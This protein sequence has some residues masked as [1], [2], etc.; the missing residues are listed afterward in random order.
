[1]KRIYLRTLLA[2][3]VGVTSGCASSDKPSFWANPLARRTADPDDPVEKKESPVAALRNPFAKQDAEGELSEEF[4][5]AQKTLKKHPEKTLLAWA[6]YQEDIGEYAEARKMYRELQIA[7]PKNMEAHLGMARIELLTGRSIQAEEILSELVKK[8]PKNAEVRLAVGRM[9]SQQERWDEAIGAFQ[10]ACEIEPE[11][12][13]CRYELGV[14]YARSGDF[15]QALSHLT[16]S[17]GE[18]AAHYNIGYILHEE[19]RDADAVEWFQNALQRHPD[20]QTAEKSKAM[21]TKLAPERIPDGTGGSRL[22][23]STPSASRPLTNRGRNAAM[24][25][26][27]SILPAGSGAV[28]DETPMVVSAR[29]VSSSPNRARQNTLQQDYDQPPLED[30]YPVESEEAFEQQSPFRTASYGESTPD[31][32]APAS[33]AQPM[34]TQTTQTAQSQPAQGQ[35]AQWH[36]PSGAASARPNGQ[37]WSAPKDPPMWKKRK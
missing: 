9:Y 29:G 23:R 32:Y 21:L 3:A 7:Y 17:V 25:P 11:N 27:R 19:G 13:N 34:P 1:M 12:Q 15:D 8:N 5:A 10:Q 26:P 18:P 31:E 20:Q 24:Q 30:Q 28:A 35:P 22:A 4:L 36:G 6:R 16:F 14:A 37:Q 33:E 2:A